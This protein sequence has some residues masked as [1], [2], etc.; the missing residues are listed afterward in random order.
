MHDILFRQCDK[1]DP[2]AF[3]RDMRRDRPVY[4]DPENDLWGIYTYKDCHAI[5]THSA[6]SISQSPSFLVGLSDEAGRMADHLARLSNVPLHEARRDASLQLFRR[7]KAVDIGQLMQYLMGEPRLPASLDWVQQ[8]C[9]RLPAF[10]LLKGL[11]FSTA[12][13]ESIVNALPD[14]V[15][16]M[17]PVKSA[18]EALAAN[19]AV[20]AISAHLHNYVVGIDSGAA[21]SQAVMYSANLAGL[22]IQSFDAGRGLLGNALLWAIREQALYKAQD[23]T[24][25]FVREVLRID[26]PVQNTRRVLTDRIVLGDVVLERGAKVL[27]VLASANRD[28]RQFNG[29]D[30]FDPLKHRDVQYFAFGSGI[31][32]CMAEHFSIG[33]TA[34]ALRYIYGHYTDVKLRENDLVYEPRVNVRLAVRMVIEVQ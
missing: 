21:R 20:E 14:L 3:Y 22:V 15:N 23:N 10:A 24:E 12:A 26:P 29:A 17:H 8:I 11:G 27:I 34:Q 32:Q 5:L 4:Y 7:W 25:A 2:Y 33:V 9:C 16:I 28:A 19:R 31:H 6:A 18:G 1:N 30:V 13:T